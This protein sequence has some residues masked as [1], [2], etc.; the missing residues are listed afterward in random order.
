MDDE[1]AAR[2]HDRPTRS[3]RVGILPGK[4]CPVFIRR[5]YGIPLSRGRSRYA[6]RQSGAI[7][8]QGNVARSGVAK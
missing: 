4:I 6:R 3:I 8:Q 1:L 2:R 7:R 5:G